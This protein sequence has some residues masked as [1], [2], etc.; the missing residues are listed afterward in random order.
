LVDVSVYELDRGVVTGGI[1]VPPYGIRKSTLVRRPIKKM[2]T[3]SHS[4]YKL[5]LLII[6]VVLIIIT[7]TIFGS[8]T[9]INVE[10][11]NT[12]HQHYEVSYVHH[13]SRKFITD[14]KVI[15]EKD[16]TSISHQPKAGDIVMGN[17]IHRMGSNKIKGK[18]RD[19]TGRG[20]W[21]TVSPL[22]HTGLP[23]HLS[24]RY[25]HQHKHGA[26]QKTSLR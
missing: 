14:N 8:N 23:S 17:Y 1:R 16:V 24:N 20:V 3:T 12:T 22:R 4:L 19:L 21:F 26:L 2:I 10:V 15:A 11:T 5:L 6:I 9:P 25:M 7:I 13:P 18:F